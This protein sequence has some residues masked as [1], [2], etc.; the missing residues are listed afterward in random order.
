MAKTYK[1]ISPR[2][3]TPNQQIILENPDFA[4]MY[5]VLNREYTF[6]EWAGELNKLRTSFRHE[7]PTEHAFGY[8]ALRLV[9]EGLVEMSK[10]TPCNCMVC[11]ED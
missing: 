8:R 6:H 4:D 7:M 5:A 1:R 11:V 2:E 3:L 9:E 10:Y